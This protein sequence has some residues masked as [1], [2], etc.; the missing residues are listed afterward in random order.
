MI[1]VKQAVLYK[2]IG[3]NKIQCLACNW[4]CK[5]EDGYTGVCGIRENI[6]GKL[7]LLAYGKPFNGLAIDPIEKKP[8]FH[9][10]PGSKILS[11]GTIGCN[12]SCDF[13]QNW[14]MSQYPKLIG[15]IIRD[16]REATREMKKEIEK[17]ET[18]LPERIVEYAKSNQIPSIAYTYNEPAIF[19][20]YAYDTAK[21][22]HSKGIKNVFVSNGYESEEALIKIHKYLDAIN[23]DLKSFSEQFYLKR[24]RAKL[25]PVLENI[26]R[27]K[28]LGIW[29]EVTT[30]II[31]TL[32]DSE[33]ELKKCADFLV[34]V[35]DS[36]PW[37]LS[38]FHPDYKV[39]NLPQTPAKTL[40]KAYEIGK[41]AG[42]KY[43]YIGNIRDTQRSTT[44]CPKCLEPL[45]TREWNNTTILDFQSGKC[46]KCHNIIEGIW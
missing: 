16:K 9:F 15:G 42:L 26:S 44:Y 28:D 21:L 43:V 25:K 2:K 33:A 29:T 7:F 37:H 22:A 32:N 30:L 45:I 27:C 3:K 46:G 14:E 23:I 38:A 31:P 24:C 39:N 8:L 20:E 11:F 41:K 13:C 17:M 18:W 40:G 1:P 34:S 6:K 35:S 36:I 5:I 10:L 19:F 12:F 4:Y